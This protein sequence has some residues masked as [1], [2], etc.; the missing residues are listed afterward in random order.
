MPARVLV[1]PFLR[2]LLSEGNKADVVDRRAHAVFTIAVQIIVANVGGSGDTEEMRAQSD[3]LLIRKK[4]F[5]DDAF[6]VLAGPSTV[7]QTT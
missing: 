4:V 6:I 3:Q 5:E 2:M 7:N 1:Y